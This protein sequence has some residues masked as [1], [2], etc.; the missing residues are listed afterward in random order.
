MIGLTIACGSLAATSR[1]PQTSERIDQGGAEGHRQR[2]VGEG[3][4]GHRE[5]VAAEVLVFHV[6]RGRLQRDV[7]VDRQVRDGRRAC[8]ARS[9]PGHS[10]ASTAYTNEL[11]HSPRSH[12]SSRLCASRRIPTRSINLAEA[13]FRASQFPI[14]R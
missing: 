7:G 8:H 13:A 9:Y 1:E 11:V 2:A 14:T 12:Q 10:R 4:A 6:R 5:D 3:P